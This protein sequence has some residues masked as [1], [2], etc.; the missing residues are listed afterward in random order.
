MSDHKAVDGD[1]GLDDAVEECVSGVGE[2]AVDQG[3]VVDEECADAACFGF[4]AVMS[5]MPGRCSVGLE[6]C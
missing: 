4:G 2:S 1:V 5:W 6:D 3:A